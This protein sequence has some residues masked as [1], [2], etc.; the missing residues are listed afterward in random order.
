LT[1]RNASAEPNQR[2]ACAVADFMQIFPVNASRYQY[3]NGSLAV[4][5]WGWNDAECG[6]TAAFICK[7]K[8]G[9]LGSHRLMLQSRLEDAGSIDHGCHK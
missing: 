7:Y 8:P 4:S 3:G 6:R 9:E 5:A 1:R 2:G